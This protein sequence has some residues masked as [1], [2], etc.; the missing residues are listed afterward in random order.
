MD[1]GSVTHVRPTRNLKL[2][3][4]RGHYLIA[5]LVDHL[6]YYV[7]AS[8]FIFYNGYGNLWVSAAEGFVFLSGFFVGYIYYPRLLSTKFINIVRSL[9]TRALLIY[10]WSVLLTILYSVIGLKVGKAPLLGKGIVYDNI[11]DIVVNAAR[12]K[13]FYGWADILSV[14]IPYVLVSP[15]ILYLIRRRMAWLVLSASFILWFLNLKNIECTRACIS[16]FNLLSWQF[17]FI[18]GI[19][20]GSRKDTFKKI[21]NTKVKSRP[22]ITLLL[23]VFFVTLYLSVLD[24]FYNLLPIQSRDMMGYL[25]GK[26][27]LGPGRIAM[28]IIWIT[29]MYLFIETFFSYLNKYLGWLFILFGKNSLATYIIQS[30]VLFAFFYLPFEYGYV[31]STVATFATLLVVWS[32]VALSRYLKPSKLTVKRNDV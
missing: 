6:S 21:Y 27:T 22:G 24:T 10:I 25:F 31:R 15:F 28:F 18:L 3:L 5:I 9:W 23:A 1:S 8:A 13:Y 4:L 32:L 20:I 29:T 14:Y 30:L 2:D 19:Y 12:F 11:L 26:L 17:L 16:V 7:G